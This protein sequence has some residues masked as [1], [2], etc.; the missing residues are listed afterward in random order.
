MRLSGIG[1]IF[2]GIT[3]AGDNWFGKDLVRMTLFKKFFPY[4]RTHLDKI[5]IVWALDGVGMLLGFTGPLMTKLTIDYAYMGR[6]ITVFNVIIV[7][8]FILF[9][10][11][12]YIEFMRNYLETRTRNLIKLSFSGR[13]Y[14]HLLHLP[15]SFFRE[16]PSGELTFRMES[17]TDGMISLFLTEL[18]TFILT[19]VRV[20]LLMA[21]CFYMNWIATLI[22]VGLVPVI[23][24]QSHFFG[25][26]HRQVQSVAMERRQ[27]TSRDL[28]EAVANIALV[29]MEAMERRELARFLRNKISYVKT[30]VRDEILG[31]FQEMT[32]GG[33]N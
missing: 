25:K 26:M 17:D 29:K 6:N 12:A 30:T 14:Y 18:P 32:S 15:Y 21:V 13:L 24:L 7:A 27:D 22:I 23:Y 4:F 1:R 10:L 33:L 20:I 5:V 2:K 28:Q 8:G 19:I 16:H 31:F 3:G 11:D 9:L